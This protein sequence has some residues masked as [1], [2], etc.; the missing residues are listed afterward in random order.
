MKRLERSGLLVFM[1]LLI[2]GWSIPCRG[3]ERPLTAQDR[4]II[5][6]Q[7]I[8]ASLAGEPASIVLGRQSRN[9]TLHT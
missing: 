6:T 7:L 3:D 9:S 1:V 5:R 2:S 4:Q 8:P